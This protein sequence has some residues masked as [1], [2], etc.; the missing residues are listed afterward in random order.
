MR[1]PRRFAGHEIVSR[2]TSQMLDFFEANTPK[3]A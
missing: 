3:T 1:A 2:T